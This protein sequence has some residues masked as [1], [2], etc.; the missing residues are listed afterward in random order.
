VR[1]SAAA[2]ATAAAACPVA[3]R[4]MGLQQQP[5]CRLVLLAVRLSAAAVRPSGAGRP[6]VQWRGRHAAV[7]M[8]LVLGPWVGLAA[9]VAVTG[10]CRVAAVLRGLLGL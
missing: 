5:V 10:G 4:L 7:G 8:L 2:A 9:G 1:C 6:R 3:C